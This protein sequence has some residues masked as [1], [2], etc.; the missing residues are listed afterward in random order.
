MAEIVILA[1]AVALIVL[2][3]ASLRYGYDDT[4]RNR[5]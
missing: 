5:P 3:T 4:G 1:L 2:G